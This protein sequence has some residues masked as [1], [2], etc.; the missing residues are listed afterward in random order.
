MV[1]EPLDAVDLY[2]RYALA[3]LP[4]EAGIGRDIDDLEV[5]S[6]NGSDRLDR[7]PAQM[8]A[9]GGEDDDARGH[10]RHF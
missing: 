8:A 1:A 9:R 3:I 2:H 10:T 4:L 6:A 7:R 5:A